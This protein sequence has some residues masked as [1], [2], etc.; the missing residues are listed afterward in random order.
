[1]VTKILEKL[2]KRE[3]IKPGPISFVINEY[4][5]IRN[6]LNKQI[7]KKAPELTGALIDFGCGSKPY[8]EYFTN[9]SEYIGVDLKIN[10]WEHRQTTVDF[11]YDGKTIPFADNH[12]DS[13]LCTEVLEHVFNIEELLGEFQRVLK[14]GGIALVTTPFM[15]EEHEVPH[16]FGRYTTSALRYLYEKHGFEIV[17]HHKT[18]NTIKIIMQFTLQYIKSILPNNKVIRQILMLPVI[19][20]CNTIATVF[21]FILPGNGTIYFNNVFMIQKK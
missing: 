11:F 14:P 18:G 15:W 2:L 3:K 20:F 9:V 13:M 5:L 4:Y 10:G 16:D 17:Y 1:M 19:F 8:E 7:I 21:S 12:F 6:E